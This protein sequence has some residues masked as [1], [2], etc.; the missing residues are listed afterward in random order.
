MNKGRWYKIESASHP[1]TY[2]SGTFQGF[3][4]NWS[5]VTNE[6]YAIYMSFHKMVLYL[7]EAHVM[8]RCDHVPQ[9][10]FIYSVTKN[11]KINNWSQGFHSITLYIDF[12]HI[13]GKENMIVD[14][15]LRLK[16]LHIYEDNDP[17][18]PGYEY[19][20]SIFDTDENAVCSVDSNQ[21]VNDE[22]EIDKIKYCL[23]GKDLTNLQFESTNALSSM[24]DTARIKQLHQQ[25]IHI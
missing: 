14:G 9:Q 22:F 8:V 12:K 20:K 3:Q 10:K 13:K 5:T 4:K 7:K 23:N 17:E 18:K 24:Y 21:N 19:G 11:D 6:S 2:Q 1:I 15:L 25:D 16:C